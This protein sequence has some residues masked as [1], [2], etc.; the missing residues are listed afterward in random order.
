MWCG[1][2]LGHDSDVSRA[3][4]RSTKP[5]VCALLVD[6]GLRDGLQGLVKSKGIWITAG[7]MACLLAGVLGLVAQFNERGTIIS[8]ICGWIVL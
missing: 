7:R 3:T 8:T 6:R 4:V 5:S 1:F 2:C